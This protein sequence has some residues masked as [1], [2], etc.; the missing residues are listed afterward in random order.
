LRRH[1]R[2]PADSANA[3]G[4]HIVTSIFRAVSNWSGQTGVR[5]GTADGKCA[6]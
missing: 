2:G 4:R 3:G 5:L 6:M 1:G